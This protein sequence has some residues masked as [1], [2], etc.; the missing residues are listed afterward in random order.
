MKLWDYSRIST[1]IFLS[2]GIKL[3][4]TLV[5]DSMGNGKPVSSTKSFGRYIKYLP[6]FLLK[7]L[8]ILSLTDQT[9]F[10]FLKIFSYNI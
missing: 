10:R 7:S 8:P 2:L 9:S 5:D 4:F 1:I 3:T 6:S